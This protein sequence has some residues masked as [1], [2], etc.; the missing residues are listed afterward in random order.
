MDCS[1]AQ[2]SFLEELFIALK[3]AAYSVESKNKGSC[4]MK[5]QKRGNVSGLVCALVSE[6][7]GEIGP[8]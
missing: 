2:I 8:P 1:C 7:L 3:L 5:T 4:K 6:H